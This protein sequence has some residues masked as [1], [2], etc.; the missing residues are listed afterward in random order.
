VCGECRL[1]TGYY[2]VC[3]SAG[4]YEGALKTVIH[5]LKYERRRELARPL[6]RFM[7]GYAGTE[8]PLTQYDCIV[9]VPLHPA[10]LRERGFNQARA[11]A[12]ECAF[13]SGVPVLNGALLRRRDG[14]S[15]SLLKRKERT[16]NVKGSFVVRQPRC[17]EG[18]CVLVVDD[19]YTTGA[20]AE[21]CAKTLLAAGASRVDVLTAARAVY[22]I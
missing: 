12:E 9:P 6:G 15:Q 20:T 5:L 19:V 8:L 18:R 13:G 4:I 22:P 11:L 3:R 21:E 17:I 10:R 2:T 16:R 14:V 1:S 7:A